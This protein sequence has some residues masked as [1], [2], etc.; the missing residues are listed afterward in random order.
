M[1]TITSAPSFSAGVEAG[2]ERNREALVRV[3]ADDVVD[4]VLAG[5]AGRPVGRA[6]VDDEPLDRVEA[7]DRAGEVGERRRQG[8]LFVQ[9]RDLD[10]ELHRLSAC[11]PHTMAHVRSAVMEAAAGDRLTVLYLIAKGRSG[12]NILAHFLGQLDG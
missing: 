7:G 5:D 6:V 2:L 1:V 4:A 10:D 12:S 11:P 3:E 9:A 8:L